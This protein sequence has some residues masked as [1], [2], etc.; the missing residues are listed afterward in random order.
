MH[1]LM[2]SL[3]LESRLEP[4][5]AGTPA[6]GTAPPSTGMRPEGLSASWNERAP[7]H[8]LSGPEPQT[9]EWSNGRPCL[10]AR[11]CLGDY[12]SP[13]RAKRPPD[14]WRFQERGG[15]LDHWPQA[16]P[17]T[18]DDVTAKVLS[19]CAAGTASRAA[20]SQAAG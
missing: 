7:P 6:P 15:H 10:P 1:P 3:V 17:A 11:E 8:R 12:A 16:W 4:A 2:V 19:G 9:G 14:A 13:L 5:Q 18:R 20:S